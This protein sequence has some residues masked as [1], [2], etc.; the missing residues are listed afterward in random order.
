MIDDETYEEL[1]DIVYPPLE[2]DDGVFLT[3]LIFLIIS[4]LI[5]G[6][7][8]LGIAG[9]KRRESES[10]WFFLGTLLGPIGILI[11][12]LT[13]KAELPP[14]MKECPF[15]DHLIAITAVECISCK[16][17]LTEKENT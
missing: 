11:A 9:S 1:V 4:V 8:T 16:T 5:C 7:I 13:P 6:I 17:D 10:I 15:C 2:P 12:L 3:V 14:N